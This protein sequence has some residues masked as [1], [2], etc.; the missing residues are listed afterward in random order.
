M[1]FVCRWKKRLSRNNTKIVLLKYSIKIKN[2]QES[3]V[4]ERVNVKKWMKYIQAITF[5]INKGKNEKSKIEN[6]QKTLAIGNSQ[7]RK[8][9]VAMSF[10][11]ERRNM[12]GLEACFP[13]YS[14]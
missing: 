10:S 12:A 3:D 6:L 7:Q 2:F 14:S 5:I 4:N 9:K 11:Y 1:E 8:K 13:T